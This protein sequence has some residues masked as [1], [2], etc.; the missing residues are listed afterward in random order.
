MDFT[1][2]QIS[3]HIRKQAEKGNGL[4][5]LMEIMPGS[6]KLAVRDEFLRE[7]PGNKGNGHRYGDAYGQGRKLEFRIPHW[8]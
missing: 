2:V 8:I 6:M 7:S 4:Y 1:K 5:D 3:E